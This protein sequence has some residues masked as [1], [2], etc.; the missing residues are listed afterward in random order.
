LTLPVYTPGEVLAAADCNNYFLPQVAV[1]TSNSSQIK[2]TT[3]ANDSVLF[4]PVAANAIYEFRFYLNAASAS[5][6]S[7]AK[8]AFTFPAGATG[9]Y[10]GVYY[11]SGG[12]SFA[13][14]T[15]LGATQTG[16]VGGTANVNYASFWNGL[17]TTSST[18]GNFQVQY[19][20]QTLDATNGAYIFAP[21]ALILNRIG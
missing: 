12:G 15:S 9:S 10:A 11:N 17:M 4:V 19:A 18:A 14:P 13:V 5:T 2:T 20:E 3:L 21:S 1:R 7:G 6:T 8:F 16:L